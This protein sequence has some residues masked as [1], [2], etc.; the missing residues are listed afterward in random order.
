MIVGYNQWCGNNVN[1]VML[2]YD[3]CIFIG[4]TSQWI[5]QSTM[6]SAHFG[7]CVWSGLWLLG[8]WSVVGLGLLGAVPNP[9]TTILIS[10]MLFSV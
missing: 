7:P 9:D 3:E 2:V 6:T 1:E 4:R 10:D 5:G 8:V